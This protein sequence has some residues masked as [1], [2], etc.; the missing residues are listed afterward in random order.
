M[1]KNSREK[2]LL[3]VNFYQIKRRNISEDSHLQRKERYISSILD[4]C[5]QEMQM[6]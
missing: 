1:A 5:I 3:S 2:N 4:L 6:L